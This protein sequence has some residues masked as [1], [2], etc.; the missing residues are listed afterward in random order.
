MIA[1]TVDRRRR[2]AA[3]WPWLGALGSGAGLGVVIALLLR[4]GA[5]AALIELARGFAAFASAR[6]GPVW[7]PMALV[8]VRV[9][10]LGGRAFATRHGRGHVGHPVRPELSQLAPLFAALGLC[11][12]VW[13]L[14]VAFDALQGGEFLTQ[15]PELL[16][17]L[18]AAMT[19]TLVGLGLQIATLLLA[20]FDPAWSRIEVRFRDG[21]VR[22]AIDGQDV[23]G[24]QHGREALCRALVARQPEALR[25]EYARDVPVH[26]RE[27]ARQ[28]IWEHTDAGVPLREVTV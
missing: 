10:W 5:G 27:I 4:S 18:G 2:L 14:S 11:G 12:T 13:G 21:D 24:G 3:L 16:S 7:V 17:G 6:V 20:A 23:G 15:V 22:F 8:A 9:L 19:S 25:V 28:T 1:T 26:D